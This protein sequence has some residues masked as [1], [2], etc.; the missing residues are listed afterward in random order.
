[1]KGNSRIRMVQL[2]IL[3]ATIPLWL[4]LGALSVDQSLPGALMISLLLFAALECFGLKTGRCRLLSSGISENKR[5]L[6]S[7]AAVLITILLMPVTKAYLVGIDGG[8]GCYVP[9]LLCAIYIWL[10]IE[11]ARELLKAT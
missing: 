11:V 2:I 4:L 5:G 9:F 8:V 6:D 3:I 7:I 10:L 1:M